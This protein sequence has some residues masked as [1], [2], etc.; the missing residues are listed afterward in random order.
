MR[1]TLTRWQKGYTFV[2]LLVVTTILL[3]LASAIMPLAK[4]TV[5][6]Q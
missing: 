4:V 5:Q 2:E 1:S 6:R 3:I